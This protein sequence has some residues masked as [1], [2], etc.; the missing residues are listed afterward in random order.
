MEPAGIGG[1]EASKADIHLEADISAAEGNKLGYGIGDFVP[2]LTVKYKVQKQGGK[3]QE[4]T[5]MPMNASD[6]PHY[7]NNIKLDG[8]GRYNITFIIENPERLGYLLHVDKETGVD[9]R[10][11]TKPIEVSWTFDYVPRKW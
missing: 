10:F 3:V 9:G 7:G 4:G 2:Y 1:L 6:G 11:W 5:F 8:A